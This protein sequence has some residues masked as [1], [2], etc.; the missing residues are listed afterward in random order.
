M[1][2]DGGPEPVRSSDAD[3]TTPTRTPN[4]T[5]SPSG[6]PR[7]SS[8]PRTPGRSTRPWYL[9]ASMSLMWL[10][11]LLGAMN[12]CAEIE[13]LRG[14]QEGHDRLREALDETDQPGVR[15][16]LVRQSAQLEG[17]ARQ[18]QVAFPLSAGH[19]VLSCLL[20]LA[21][22][23]ALAGRKGS[24]GLALQ[25]V[26]ASAALAV[27]AYALLGPVR[28]SVAVAVAEDA[29]LHPELDPA[30]PTPADVMAAYHDGQLQ[31][32]RVWMAMQL[33]GFAFAGLALTRRRTKSY[34]AAAEAAAAAA[35]PPWTDGDID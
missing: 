28:E 5:R 21:A 12:G 14:S 18:H 6:A 9:V 1:G 30:Q 34:F 31:A 8:P 13:Y 11:G 24:R 29:V 26:G 20:V 4:G 22:G 27:A 2:Q 10:V 32:E 23:A 35:R 16:L 15:A 17:M 7:A 3:P 25:A 33:A 19:F